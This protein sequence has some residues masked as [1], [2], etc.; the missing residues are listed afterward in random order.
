MTA[1]P[2][3]SIR[4]SCIELV[5]SIDRAC[6]AADRSDESVASVF[7]VAVARTMRELAAVP[8]IHRLRGRVREA[9]PGEIVAAMHV[10][11]QIAADK[12]GVGLTE[13]LIDSATKADKPEVAAKLRKLQAEMIRKSK[14]EAA[15]N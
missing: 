3:E 9:T 1:A 15:K 13:S 10:M 2:F 11:A 7:D 8:A 14:A 5:E 12:K 6:R 4:Q